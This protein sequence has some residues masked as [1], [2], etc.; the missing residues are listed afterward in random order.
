MLCRAGLGQAQKYRECPAQIGTVGN[1]AIDTCTSI[2]KPKSAN[3][4][5]EA[6]DSLSKKPD[7]VLNGYR[8]AGIVDV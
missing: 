5:I 6:L 8:K 4:L 2:V 3:W 7:I 1:Y